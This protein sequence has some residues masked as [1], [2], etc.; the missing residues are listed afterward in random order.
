MFYSSNVSDV[1]PLAR[2]VKL[3][4]ILTNIIAVKKRSDNLSFKSKNS[5]L[6]EFFNEL[7]KLNNVNPQK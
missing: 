4:V 2:F 6:K 5:F 3:V 1:L 7:G